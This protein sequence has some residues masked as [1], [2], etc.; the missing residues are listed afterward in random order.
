MA[1]QAVV[2]AQSGPYKGAALVGTHS[3]IIGWSFDDP[4][5]RNGLLGFAI[6]R[7]EIDLQTDEILRLRWLGGY[8]R[9]EEND[10]GQSGDVSSLQA[11]FQRFRWNDYTLRQD[12]KYVYEVYPMRGT[13]TALTR[14]EAPLRF[15]FEASKEDQNDLGVYVNRGVTSAMAYLRRF[16]NRHPS[17]VGPPAYAWLSRGLKE[18]LLKFIDGCAVGDEMHIA[19]YEF[20][21]EE[22]VEHVKNAVDR[23]VTVSIVYDHTD[24]KK[25]TRESVEMLE[26]FHLDSLAI[27]RTNVNISHNKLVIRLVNGDPHSVWTGSA[28]FSENAFN[29]QSNTALVIRD[30]DL[31]ESYEDYF[32]A[33]TPN[34]TKANSK[35]INKDL[36]AAYNRISPRFA[37]KVYYSPIRAKDI[38]D[39]SADLVSAASSMVLVSAPFG[40][41]NRIVEAL[42]M[43]SENIVEYGLV[44]STAKRKIENLRRRNTRFFTPK[45]LKTYMGRTWDAK[46]F[47]AHKIHAKF[48]IVDPYG[49]NPQVLI[50]S[51]NFST[52]SCRDNDE[53][54]LL[55]S[56]DKRLAAILATE[57]MRMYDHYK[58]RFYIDKIEEENKEIE[59]ENEDRL[60][61]GL[62]PLPEKELGIYLKSDESWSNTAY[63]AT[64]WS[65]K[66]QDRIAFIGS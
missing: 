60:A 7:I 56:G 16:D 8:K 10:E 35:L 29:F 59:E 32:H 21:D 58:A 5:L 24:G 54:A 48:I 51:A 38:L 31:V 53:N 45:R 2:R 42:L 47:G 6:K 25:S 66:F 44:N 14:N 23:G 13:P 19:I 9:F 17:E 39:T 34:P 27:K 3:A 11:P 57:F 26:H 63:N 46:A 62:D 50:G 41:D 37:D 40:L 4:N 33:L 15:Q 61:Q 1:Y 28:N 12:R 55:I 65:H 43:N 64:S 22:V 49:D 18:S 36:M 30:K 52:A 20:F